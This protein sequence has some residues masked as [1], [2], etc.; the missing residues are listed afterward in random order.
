MSVVSSIDPESRRDLKACQRLRLL[1]HWRS[2][3]LSR[4]PRQPSL[5]NCLRRWPYDV[6]WDEYHCVHIQAL[7]A[8]LA[9]TLFRLFVECHPPI[10]MWKPGLSPRESVLRTGW[11]LLSVARRFIRLLPA[12]ISNLS[13]WTMMAPDAFSHPWRKESE[14]TEGVVEWNRRNE[15]WSASWR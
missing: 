13:L 7:N 14:M 4:D 12:L 11:S 3:W 8:R 2:I 1:I 6:N 15:Q 9:Q 5:N 10:E